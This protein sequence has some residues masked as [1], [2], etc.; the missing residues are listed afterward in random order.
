MSIGKLIS[1]L[2]TCTNDVLLDMRKKYISGGQGGHVCGQGG[3]CTQSTPAWEKAYASTIIAQEAT[4]MHMEATQECS[5]QVRL[6]N[7]WERNLALAG[8]SL[9]LARI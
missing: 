6:H 5:A 4:Y 8:G 2:I 7:A 9:N 3:T 1:V